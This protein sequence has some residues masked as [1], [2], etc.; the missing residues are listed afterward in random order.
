MHNYSDGLDPV[1]T[2]GA[3]VTGFSGAGVKV[4]VVAGLVVVV[5]GNVVDVV[6]VDVVV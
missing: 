5:L 1:M 2:M 3:V 4:V 6:D